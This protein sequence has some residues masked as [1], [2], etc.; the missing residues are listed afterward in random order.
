[1]TTASSDSTVQSF[2]RLIVAIVTVCSLGVLAGCSSSVK[3]GPEAVAGLTP[4]GTVDMNE[5]QVAP[6]HFQ[7]NFNDSRSWDPVLRHVARHGRF[8]YA[9][10][11][12]T[13]ED[14][15]YPAMALEMLPD[16]SQRGGSS[17]TIRVATRQ[18]AEAELD[19]ARRFG[20]EFVGS[21]EPDYPP[22][23][24]QIEDGTTEIRTLAIATA[25]AC[26]ALFDGPKGADVEIV[27]A[28]LRKVRAEGS[29]PNGAT[30]SK[31]TPLPPA[32]TRL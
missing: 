23:L 14:L 7:G 4:S 16:L 19:H 31:P 1:M 13:L 9:I 24:R 2:Y 22:A 32:D 26:R 5:V 20:A 25:A 30:V 6:L 29:V 8:S 15:A 11:S 12:H 21:G 28:V 17:R 10:C 3:I 27:A 18:E